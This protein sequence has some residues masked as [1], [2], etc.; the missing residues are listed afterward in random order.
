MTLHDVV[1]HLC[2]GNLAKLT[3]ARLLLHACSTCSSLLCRPTTY[4]LY[5]YTMSQSIGIVRQHCTKWIM[6]SFC[7]YKYR[8]MS[9]E[10][11]GLLAKPYVFLR[12]LLL[13]AGDVEPNP[14]PI[15]GRQWAAS[16]LSTIHYFCEYLHVDNCMLLVPKLKY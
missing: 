15:Q 13:L 2:H 16:Y 9:Q 12:E 5:W 6:H 3:M 14:G 8:A 1:T 7:R 11:C 4:I 10:L